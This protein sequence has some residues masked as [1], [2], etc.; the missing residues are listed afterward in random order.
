LGPKANLGL[1]P[2]TSNSQLGLY[3]L[4]QGSSIS[5]WEPDGFQEIDAVGISR[6]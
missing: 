4:D 1:L 3:S 2:G 5:N 6:P